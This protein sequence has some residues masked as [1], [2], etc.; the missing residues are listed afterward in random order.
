MNQYGAMAMKHWAEF[1]PLR[2]RD[3]TDPER[4]FTTLGQQ[5]E[6]EIAQREMELRHR[7]TPTE[8]FLRTARA[9]STCHLEA[10][11][12]VLRE[13]VYVEPEVEE[14]DPP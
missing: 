11:Q 1:L 4:F 13:M 6:E 7:I 8:D 2:F 10:E 5:V 12:Q 3:L 9:Y 14:D